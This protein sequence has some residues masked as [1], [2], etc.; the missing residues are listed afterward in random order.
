MHHIMTLEAIKVTTNSQLTEPIIDSKEHCCGIV[1]PIIKQT[2][3]QYKKLQHD[4]NLKHLWVPA[5]SKEVHPLAQ[6]N[7]GITNKTNTIFFLSPKQVRYIPTDW[8][9]MYGRIVIDNCP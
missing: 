3:T 7:P 6:G 9:V 4:P 2:I 5:M 8:T 1:H